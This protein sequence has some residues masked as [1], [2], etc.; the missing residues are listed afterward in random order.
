M[1][2]VNRIRLMCL[3]QEAVLEY[4]VGGPLHLT[5]TLSDENV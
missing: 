3:R 4:Y 1:V 2:T 5:T